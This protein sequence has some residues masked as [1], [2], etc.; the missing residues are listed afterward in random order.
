MSDSTNER[1]RPQPLTAEEHELAEHIRDLTFQLFKSHEHDYHAGSPC[2]MNRVSHGA[3]LA[4]S[5]GVGSAHLQ[6]L[7]AAIAMYESGCPCGVPTLRESD[8]ER[9]AAGEPV[10]RRPGRVRCHWP[11]CVIEG[12]HVHCPECGSTEHAAAQC[13]TKG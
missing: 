9:H 7:M 10:E 1:L 6:K 4:H 5:L 3:W 2:G 13:A 8:F 12:E 11:A